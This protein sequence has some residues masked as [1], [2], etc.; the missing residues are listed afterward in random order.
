[1]AGIRVEQWIPYSIPLCLVLPHRGEREK[2][3]EVFEA[4][5]FA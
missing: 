5:Y 3:A 1:M 4:F 2:T